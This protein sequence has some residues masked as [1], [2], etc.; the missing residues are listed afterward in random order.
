MRSGRKGSARRLGEVFLEPWVGGVDQ[1]LGGAV[2]DDSA[3]VEDEKLGAVVDAAIGDLFD[4]AGLLIETVS[5]EEEGIL[6]AMGD[7]ERGCVGDVAL[8]DD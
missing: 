6:Q 8:F 7:D 4:L 1:F 3:F 2:E 5:G